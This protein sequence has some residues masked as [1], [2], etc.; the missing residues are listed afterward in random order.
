VQLSGFKPNGGDGYWPGL[1]TSTTAF[2]NDGCLLADSSQLRPLGGAK[3]LKADAK[4]LKKA[5]AA[6]GVSDLSRITAE[7]GSP[8]GKNLTSFCQAHPGGI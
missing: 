6:T 1:G 8:A 3:Y 2:G 4:D 5:L 7:D